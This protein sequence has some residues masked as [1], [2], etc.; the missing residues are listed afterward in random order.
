MTAHQLHADRTLQSKC[1]SL[2]S[3]FS[4]SASSACRPNLAEQVHVLSSDLWMEVDVHRDLQLAEW[5]VDDTEVPGDDTATG[6]AVLITSILCH[7]LPKALHVGNMDHGSRQRVSGTHHHIRTHISSSI[8]NKV[9]SLHMA[10]THS[11]INSIIFRELL[12]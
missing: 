9:R 2:S 10:T 6:D 4:N 5:L 11:S 7:P 12:G 3:S 1:M 8:H